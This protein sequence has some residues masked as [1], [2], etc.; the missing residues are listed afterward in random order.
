MSY[1]QRIEFL[2]NYRQ[3]CEWIKP[4]T[5]GV[6][7]NVKISSCFCML[8][9]LL[10]GSNGLGLAETNFVETMASPDSFPLVDK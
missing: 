2:Q 7:A 8:G 1:G 10:L 9:F 5:K 4:T 6:T 3:C